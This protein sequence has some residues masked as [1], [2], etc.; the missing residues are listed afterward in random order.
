MDVMRTS[1]TKDK[2][3]KN[4]KRKNVCFYYVFSSIFSYFSL[5]FFLILRFRPPHH[6]MK[7]MNPICETWTISVIPLTSM[8]PQ[9]QQKIR[10]KIIE[11]RVSFPFS[12]NPLP[13]DS[14][15]CHYRYQ[16]ASPFP[17]ERILVLGNLRSKGKDAG[18]SVYSEF[19]GN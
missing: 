7:S 10:I 6:F 13:L 14:C 17:D 5:L 12:Q 11:L 18:Q 19:Y 4:K 9:K 15:C 2:Y 8:N 1:K 3:N 16:W